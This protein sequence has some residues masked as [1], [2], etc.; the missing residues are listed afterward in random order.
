MRRCGELA[1]SL[2]AAWP[3][4]FE[5]QPQAPEG[6]SRIAFEA[7][8]GSGVGGRRYSHLAQGPGVEESKE[9]K[10]RRRSA[11]QPNFSAAAPNDTAWERCAHAR[12]AAAQG[13]R[14]GSEVSPS[15]AVPYC[16]CLAART[17]SSGDRSSV[18]LL[19]G[20]RGGRLLAK[21][22]RRRQ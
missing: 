19:E 17:P 22:E 6:A 18:P 10:A 16:N 21:E 7:H 4:S 8:A 14:A 15:P 3:Y 13:P 1:I 12:P 20:S 11:A 2:A 9:A 5:P